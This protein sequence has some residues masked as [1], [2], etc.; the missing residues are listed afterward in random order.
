[1]AVVVRFVPSPVSEVGLCHMFSTRTS[2][3]STPGIH[4][5][6]LKPHAPCSR[7]GISDMFR[8]HLGCSEDIWDMH[9]LQEPFGE[10]RDGGRKLLSQQDRK[11]LV[12]N[13]SDRHQ[14]EWPHSRTQ[15]ASGTREPNPAC[16]PWP[17]A[18]WILTSQ[19]SQSVLQSRFSSSPLL[20]NRHHHLL[21]AETEV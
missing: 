8:G 5:W 20:S 21:L 14:C 13:E 1:M 2:V 16:P 6:A 12:L 10:V 18:T 19:P 11:F 3:V 7:S 4:H 15:L 9:L 17:P